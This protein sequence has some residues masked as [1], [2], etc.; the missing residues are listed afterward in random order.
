MLSS[1]EILQRKMIS[2]YASKVKNFF[3]ELSQL[4]FS[5]KEQVWAFIHLMIENIEG[6]ILNIFNKIF[7]LKTLLF[8]NPLLSLAF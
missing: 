4:D 7:D 8:L 6:Q 5:E 2:V 3:K 1:D